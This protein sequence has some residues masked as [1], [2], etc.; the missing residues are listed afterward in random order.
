MHT[1]SINPSNFLSQS[2]FHSTFKYL[3]DT[4]G[5]PSL[6]ISIKFGLALIDQRLFKSIKG[7]STFINIKSILFSTISFSKSVTLLYQSPL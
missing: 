4:F 6:L 2:D 3:I 7:V 1:N 5:N